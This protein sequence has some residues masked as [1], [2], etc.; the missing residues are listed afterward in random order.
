MNHVIS[1]SLQS[2]FAVMHRCVKSRQSQVAFA[3]GSAAESSALIP[4]Y[5]KILILCI[6]SMVLFF[7][8]SRVVVHD[9]TRVRRE[10]APLLR[11]SRLC[12]HHTESDDHMS[13]KLLSNEP[14]SLRTHLLSCQWEYTWHSG[15]GETSEENYVSWLGNSL[16]KTQ[17]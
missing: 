6:S 8:L 15:G 13:E 10:D 1:K 4:R 2:D 7:F 12:D 17:R 9:N 16:F 5:H 11:V 3:R 14:S